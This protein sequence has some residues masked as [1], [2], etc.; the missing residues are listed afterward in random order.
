MPLC[1]VRQGACLYV[2]FLHSASD[3]HFGSIIGGP[4]AYIYIHT[5]TCKCVCTCT[6]NPYSTSEKYTPLAPSFF[7]SGNG[8]AAS[9]WL[10]PVLSII[11]CCLF[12]VPLKP[13]SQWT[14]QEGEVKVALPCGQQPLSLNGV[15]PSLLLSD[16]SH[17][18]GCAFITFLSH[19][20]KVIG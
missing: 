11:S 5:H 17:I 15:L 2:S 12:H 19:I 9:W 18:P 13:P 3:I 16:R 8:A 4:L 1:R 6:Y 7:R 10:D 14:P 20:P